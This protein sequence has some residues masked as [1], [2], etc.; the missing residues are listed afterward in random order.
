VSSQLHRCPYALITKSSQFF[1]AMTDRIDTSK[2]L[3]SLEEEQS[4]KQVKALLE[5]NK[6]REALELLAKSPATDVSGQ[7]EPQYLLGTMYYSMGRKDDAR[8][9]LTIARTKDP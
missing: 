7:G 8:R 4:W 2:E 3:K 6:E 5:A 9:V 1:D